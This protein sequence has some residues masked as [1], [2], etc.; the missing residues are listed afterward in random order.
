M[1]IRVVTVGIRVP[2]LGVLGMVQVVAAEHLAVHLAVQ[3]IHKMEVL[4]MLVVILGQ[5]M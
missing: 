4:V 3:Q 5:A 1:G 2:L